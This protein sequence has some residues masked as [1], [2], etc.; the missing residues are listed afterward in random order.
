MD[1]SGGQILSEQEPT[2][3]TIDITPEDWYKIRLKIA[4]LLTTIKYTV[5]EK[6]KPP[7][8]TAHVHL[9]FS[10]LLLDTMKIMIEMNQEAWV[11]LYKKQLELE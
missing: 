10:C 9:I 4:D 11:E 2:V 7:I 6:L 5:I 8:E 3:I 1:S